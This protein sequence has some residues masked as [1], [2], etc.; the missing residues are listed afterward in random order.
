M[1]DLIPITSQCQGFLESPNSA[2]GKHVRQWLCLG[3]GKLT[4]E[5]HTILALGLQGGCDNV[6]TNTTSASSLSSPVLTRFDK[7]Q[8]LTVVTL[9]KRCQ[10]EIKLMSAYCG[11]S[12][13]EE[14]NVSLL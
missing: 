10:D 14:K 3:P 1:N 12:E 2:G 9:D 7:T 4:G 8:V 11:H 5:P 13:T 6:A